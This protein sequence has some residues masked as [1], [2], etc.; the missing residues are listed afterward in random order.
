[1]PRAVTELNQNKLSLLSDGAPP[2]TDSVASY[3]M[4][5]MHDVLMHIYIYGVKNVNGATV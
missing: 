1:M 4:I 3:S 2:I 5:I